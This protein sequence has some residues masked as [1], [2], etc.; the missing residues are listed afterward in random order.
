MFDYTTDPAARRV[1]KAAHEE[2]GKLVRDAFH[3]L[4]HGSR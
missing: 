4:L 2:R 1:I 3:W